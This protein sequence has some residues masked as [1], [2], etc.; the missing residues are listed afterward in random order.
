[1]IEINAFNQPVISGLSHP[2]VNQCP[3]HWLQILETTLVGDVVVSSLESFAV[4]FGDS[5]REPSLS[6]LWV[7]IGGHV[8]VAVDS[9]DDLWCNPGRLRI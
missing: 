1:V 6:D 4:A 8:Q 2:V 3:V 9:G 5:K 7:G